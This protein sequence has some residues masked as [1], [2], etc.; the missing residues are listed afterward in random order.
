MTGRRR[1][2]GVVTIVFLALGLATAPGWAATPTEPAG[3]VPV[4]IHE[5]P[6]PVPRLP[7]ADALLTALPPFSMVGLRWQDA[8]PDTLAVRARGLHGQWGE[9]REL[10]P[11]GGVDS[12]EAATEPVWVGPSDE[13]QVRARR[14]GAPA[15]DLRAVLVDPGTSTADAAPPLTLFGPGPVITRAGWGADER[16]RCSEPHYDDS[17]RAIT[18][19][20]TADPGNDYGPADSPRIVRAIY[21]YHART[22]GWCDI[23]YQALVDRYGQLFEGRA[24]GLE[25]TVIGAHAGGFNR[26]TAGVAMIGTFTSELVPS[27]T[28]GA[29]QRYMSWKA[30]AHGLSANGRTILTSTGGGTSRFPAGTRVEVPV[31]FGHREVGNTIC[32]GEGGM[33]VLPILRAGATIGRIFPMG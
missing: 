1:L 29:L 27:A 20:H 18:L 32:L 28:L 22:L 14:A 21:A 12:A 16:L 19:H 25:R 6:V 5:L 15:P 11:A 3:P 23:G 24:G 2:C 13:L 17:V 30:R 31:F 9:W 26:R 4:D 10:D 33:A 8:L 7:G